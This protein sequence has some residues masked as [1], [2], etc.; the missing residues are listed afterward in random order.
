MSQIGQ[1]GPP[2]NPKN[3]KKISPKGPWAQFW[4]Q[5]RRHEAAALEIS[6][7]A[8][9]PRCMPLHNL[10]I[11]GLPLFRK[12]CDHCLSKVIPMGG[13]PGRISQICSWALDK[14]E[15]SRNRFRDTIPPLKPHGEQTLRIPRGPAVSRRMAPSIFE[16]FAKLPRT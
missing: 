6:A 15:A 2:R 12:I 7:I 8:D 10:A 16:S 14:R 13:P 1:G 9:L 11:A 4:A 5:G 3:Q